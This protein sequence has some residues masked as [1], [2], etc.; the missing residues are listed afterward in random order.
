MSTV[1]TMRLVFTALAIALAAF[2]AS[3]GSGGEAG[4]AADVVPADVAVYA[5]VD[6]DFEGDEWQALEELAARFPGGGNLLQSL[7]DEAEGDVDF[8]RDVLPALGSE[9]V[10]ALLELE[11]AATAEPSAVGEEPFVVLLQPH[12]E[13]AFDRLVAESEEEIVVG[14]VEGWR[15]LT[16]RQEWLDRF[17]AGLDG[18]RL[19]DSE[20]F[21][22]A[23]D[24]LDESSLARVFVNGAS[25][26]AAAEADA[27]AGKALRL[28][29]GGQV[30]SLGLALHAEDD[31]ARLDGRAVLAGE[32]P[33]AGEPYEA[34][35]PQE[36]PG[37]VLAYVSF[38]DLE[39][40]VSAYRDLAAEADPE[41]EAQ[42][43]M[44]EG[45]LGLSLE[46][47]VAPLFAGEGALYVR[48][49]AEFPEV[50]LVT[51]IEDDE[52]AV[53]T[54]DEI[55]SVLGAFDGRF[56]EP[57]RTE[58]DGVEVRELQLDAPFSLFYTAFEDLLVVTTS[59]EGIAALR[60][61]DDRL[62]D[63]D[64][65]EEAAD[66]ARLPDETEGFGYVDLAEALPFFLS[67]AKPGEAAAEEARTHL[68]P[69][70]SLVFY[71]NAEGETAS[72][73]VFVGVE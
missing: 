32:S 40:A 39:S 14:E 24:G 15:V 22:R 7:A 36:V 2:L 30:P 51:R 25:L 42:L 67:H 52:S 1:R 60:E 12:D 55:A 23:M 43:G 63:D 57:R 48:R 27:R 37:D 8:E 17:Q 61:D 34:D 41:A 31:G 62:A 13:A 68:D 28:L 49:G 11:P 4:G 66:R 26:Q 44:A 35:L 29:P 53:A 21:Q 9:L 5:S 3:C 45:L 50:T 59:R 71:G 70:E 6:T 65:F 10:L 58:V 72:F 54:L 46:E 16:E 33:F 19:D 47:D 56:G 64:A 20:D 73:T 38:N 18:P 69:L